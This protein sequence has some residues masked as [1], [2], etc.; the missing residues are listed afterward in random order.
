MSGG[1]SEPRQDF[2]DGPEA[3]LRGAVLVPKL[4]AAGYRVKVLDLF[5]YGGHVLDD[6]SDDPG[7]EHRMQELDLE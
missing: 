2:S 7:L 3:G 6:V 5:I 1:T 4:L